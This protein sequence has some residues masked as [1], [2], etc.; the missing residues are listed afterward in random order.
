MGMPSLELDSLT[1]QGVCLHDL[2]FPF[3]P[4]PE[5]QTPYLMLFFLSCLIT[6]VSFLQPWLYKGP[7]VSFQLAFQEFFHMGMSF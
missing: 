7:S 3:S 1:S 2:P 6:C 4:L 5:A